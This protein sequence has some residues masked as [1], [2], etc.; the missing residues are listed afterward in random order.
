MNPTVDHQ[1]AR[2]LSHHRI[3][4]MAIKRHAKRW[5]LMDCSKKNLE[6]MRHALIA[7]MET[8]EQRLKETNHDFFLYIEQGRPLETEQ[9]LQTIEHLSLDWEKL[10]EHLQE[11]DNAILERRLRLRLIRLLG[12]E[13]RLNVLDTAVFISILVVVGLVIADLLWALP[14]AAVGWV[15]GIDTA[16]CLFLIGD[17]ILRWSQ[18]LDKG[19][20][21]RR[22]WLDLVSSIPY[23]GFLRF[24]RLV[25]LTRFARLLRL[26]RLGQALQSLFISAR[27]MEKLMSQLDLL[28]RAVVIA[29]ILLVLGAVG[30]STLESPQAQAP[31]GIGEG[32]WWSFGTMVTGGFA[33]VYNPRT[34]AGRLVTVGL[35][36][37]GLTVT[38]IFTASLTSVLVEDDSNRIERRQRDLEAQLATLDEKFD[39]L[40]QTIT[41][42]TAAQE[43]E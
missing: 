28:R 19:W 39:W 18:T 17:F 2:E 4:V 16:V 1:K 8:L 5:R 31:Q 42:S 34:P 22:Y 33:D 43:E 32:L 7:E 37:L 29:L 23:V 14:P 38:G 24:G 40:S 3:E 21:L 26:V 20:Y 41:L 30:I 12:G 25:R 13:K 9:A 11:I 27:D 35:V 36:L 10:N 15:V 6:R